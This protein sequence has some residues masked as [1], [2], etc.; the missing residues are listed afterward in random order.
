MVDPE[1]ALR[2]R[3]AAVPG[4]GHERRARDRTPKTDAD[5]AACDV[6]VED[7]HHQP[8]HDGG[9]HRAASGAACGTA[10]ASRTTRRARV[11]T[12]RGDCSPRLYGLDPGAGARDRA[13][14]RWRLRREVTAPTPRRSSLGWLRPA[15]RA[16]G[17]LGGDAAP[18]TWSRFPR[19]RAGA[20]RQARRHARRAHHRVPARRRPGRGAYPLDFGALLPRMTMR[21]ATRRA[22]SSRT[23]TSAAQSVRHQHR[24]DDRVPGRG[25]A[26]GRRRHRAHGRPVRRRDRHRSRRG[27]P[28]QPASRRFTDP[29]HDG[30]RAR[31]TTSATTRRRSTGC[32]SRRRYDELRA[33]QRVVG[34]RRRSGAARHRHRR[35]TSRS[36]PGAPGHASSARSRCIPTAR[37]LV[38]TG[39]LAARPG[40]R[41]DVGA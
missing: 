1:V 35:P 8:A 26:G 23:S 13:R 37:L 14:R 32:S 7:A 10:S 19:A 24:V 11:R 21:M 15:G 6:V 40:A 27:A 33:E 39:F 5:F 16:S 30:H 17:A 12:R 34:A 36:P 4:H 41:H 25:S 9:A 2:G 3:R 29:L 28:A 31:A 20:A 22:T 38:R 18:S